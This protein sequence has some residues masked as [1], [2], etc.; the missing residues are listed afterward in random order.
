MAPRH[1]TELRC[2]SVINMLN[3]EVVGVSASS[4]MT[5]LSLSYKR[6]LGSDIISGAELLEMAYMK[7]D[8]VSKRSKAKGKI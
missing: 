3:V 7:L 5:G 6:Y 4:V 2:Y 8:T 1:V